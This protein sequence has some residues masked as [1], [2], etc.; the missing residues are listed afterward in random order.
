MG[1]SSPGFAFA[2]R[3]VARYS[4][5]RPLRLQLDALLTQWSA[6]LSPCRLDR[7][8]SFVDGWWQWLDRGAVVDDFSASPDIRVPCRRRGGSGGG[9]ERQRRVGM[10]SGGAG[11]VA[12][13][14]GAERRRWRGSGPGSRWIRFRVGMD[15]FWSWPTGP[16]SKCS[17]WWDP[18]VS[19][20]SY[21][22]N[23]V[24]RARV[25]KATQTT[26]KT[27]HDTNLR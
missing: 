8:L 21:R 15:I 4:W 23:V 5:R 25:G 27:E 2:C 3:A 16:A 18:P 12:A 14:S 11:M 1:L 6:S 19:D 7:R 22:Q 9:A 10:S 26:S 20:G 24:V 13:S 17:P